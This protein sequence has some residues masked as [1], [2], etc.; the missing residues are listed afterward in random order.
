MP[1]FNGTGPDGAGAMTGGGRGLCNMA[2]DNRGTRFATGFGRGLGF[3][4]RYMREGSGMRRRAFGGGGLGW[5][6]PDPAGYY[7]SDAVDEIEM[8]KNQA[9]YAKNSLDA[10]NRRIAELEKQSE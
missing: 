2:N 9:N 3:G 1:G 5:N 7:A 6:Q 8:L 10:I 4:R